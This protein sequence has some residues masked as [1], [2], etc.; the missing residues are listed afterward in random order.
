MFISGTEQLVTL[1]AGKM[2][3]LQNQSGSN[4]YLKYDGSNVA[5]TTSNGYLLEPGDLV[6]LDN[7]QGTRFFTGPVSAISSGTNALLHVHGE[8]DTAFEAETGNWVQRVLTNG[9]TTPSAWTIKCV[10]T[11]IKDMKSAGIFNKMHTF[12]CFVPDSLIAAITPIVASVGN[13]PWTNT[14]FTSAALSIN[15]LTSNGSQ[16]LNTGVRA[17]SML[18][19]NNCGMSVYNYTTP[20]TIYCLGV[21]DTTDA[22][23]QRFS[24]VLNNITSG[25]VTGYHF[26]AGTGAAVSV[27]GLGSY[28][29]GFW[30]VNR[31]SV[32]TLNLCSAN[33]SNAFSRLAQNLA[34][35]TST[36]SDRDV[37]AFG[38]YY[39]GAS[40]L[41]TLIC[42]SYAAIHQGLTDFEA[43]L[44][45]VIVD[46][47]RRSIGGGYV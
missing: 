27:G 42:L 43:S 21:R 26:G 37:Y 7:S 10:D 13:D 9:G 1:Q 33:S 24:L 20:S 8:D 5:L 16:W 14:N 39:N 25:I 44:E 31:L 36:P 45:F 41:A 46:N 12:C 3:H 32:S 34:S 28:S 6:L 35:N 40:V 11:L 23:N 15:G 30:T 18:D 17:A 29:T 22:N 4:I 38:E 47:F 19:V 2:M